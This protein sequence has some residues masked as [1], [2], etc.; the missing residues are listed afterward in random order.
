MKQIQIIFTDFDG[1]LFSSERKISGQDISTLNELGKLGI[2]RVIATGRS[3]FSIS[4]VI[5]C[6]FPVDYLIFS[7]GSGIMDWKNKK[8]LHSHSLNKN[9]ISEITCILSKHQVD[10]MVHYPI[11]ENHRFS[12]FQ[13]SVNNPDFLHR[14]EIYRDYI[15]RL[16]DFKQLPETACQF[17]GIIDYDTMQYNKIKKSFKNGL[18]KFEIIRTTSPLNG[19]SIWIEIFPEQVSKGKAAQWICNYLTIPKEVTM[20]IGND[21]ND[22]DLLKWTKYS[23]VVNNSPEEFREFFTIAEGTTGS[24]FSDAVISAL[25]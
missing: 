2:I 19:K 10:F 8:I 3:V 12:Y 9:E 21:F 18:N 16:S 1:T 17:V 11:P 20:S 14:C 22:V 25:T 5:E 23:Y 4:K 6:D 24:D 13:F 7:S 15:N